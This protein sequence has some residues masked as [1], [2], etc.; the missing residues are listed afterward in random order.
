MGIPGKVYKDTKYA[1]YFI[2]AFIDINEKRSD[3]IMSFIVTV[4]LLI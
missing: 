1:H 4:V 3:A 2:L